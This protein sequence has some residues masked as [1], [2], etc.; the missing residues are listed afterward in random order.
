MKTIFRLIFCLLLLAGWGLAA[1]SLHVVRT[2]EQIPVTLVPKD[3]LG[4]TDT[5]VDTRNWTTDD[6]E[7]HPELVSRLINTGNADVLRHVIS[8]PKG[9]VSAQLSDV[10]QRAPKSS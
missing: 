2:N 7:Q 5:Y 3:R 8:D 1:L 9:D 4:V 10:L 6:V